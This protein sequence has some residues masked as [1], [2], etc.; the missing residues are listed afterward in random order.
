MALIAPGS[1]VADIRGS[2]GDVTYARNA[3]GLYVRAR[4]SPDQPES[5]ERD[6]R[7]AALTALSQAWSA[8]LTEAQRSTWRTYAAR[9]PMPNRLGRLRFWDGLRHFIRCNAQHYRVSEAITFSSAPPAPPTYPPTFT[10]GAS[11]MPNILNFS[12]PP[13]NYDPPPTGMRLYAYAGLQVNQGVTYYSGP[14]RYLDWTEFDGDSWADLP[15][16]GAV[17]YDMTPG[18]RV[19]AR[20]VAVLAAGETSIA[21]HTY[22]DY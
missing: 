1:L 5:S 4:T 16:G 10:I 7:Q 17:W 11:H 18:H 22:D 13:S 12:V 6:K 15:L 20:L 21:G 14:W 8:T 3:S 2:V 9:F 19:F